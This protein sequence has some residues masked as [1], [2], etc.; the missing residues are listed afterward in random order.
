MLLCMRTTVDIRD[1][2]MRELKHLAAETRR[3][4]K[5]VFDD[6]LRSEL[7]RRKAQQGTPKP[8]RVI[9]YKGNGV[10]PGV[11]LDSMSELL[12]TMDSRG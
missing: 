12:D 3:S 9:T 11:H 6:I 2:L 10:R 5:D 1:D 8:A 7:A 4:L